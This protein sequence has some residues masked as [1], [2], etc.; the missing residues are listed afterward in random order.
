NVHVSL[1]SFKEP[2]YKIK[3]KNYLIRIDELNNSE[4]RYASWK[5]GEKESSK[6][7]I[8]LENG[9]WKFQGSVENHVITFANGDYIYNVH[10]NIIGEADTPDFTLEV[11]KNGNVIL[12][13]SGM[14]LVE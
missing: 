3:T 13:E 4:Y 14:F 6:P 12:T 10:R 8:V 11:E 2:I 9:E 1:Q 7:D 5:I